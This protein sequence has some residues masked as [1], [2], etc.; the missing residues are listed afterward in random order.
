M[1][2]KIT[3]TEFVCCLGGGL[4]G[5]DQYRSD[6]GKP[7]RSPLWKGHCERWPHDC[8]QRAQAGAQ[9]SGD[10]SS[11]GARQLDS[12]L[13]VST[14]QDKKNKGTRHQIWGE[15]REGFLRTVKDF[16]LCIFIF[17]CRWWQGNILVVLTH[18]KWFICFWRLKW[19]RIGLF[20]FCRGGYSWTGV[21]ALRTPDCLAAAE[22]VSDCQSSGL[23]ALTTP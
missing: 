14:K 18:L 9:E 21:T 16:V 8:L 20:L 5:Y 13:S 11:L 3:L 2:L 4:P 17:G 22:S 23:V 6:D 10:R 1:S 12:F 19:K 15:L 7:V